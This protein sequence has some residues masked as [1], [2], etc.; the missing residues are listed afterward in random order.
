MRRGGIRVRRPAD[1]LPAGAVVQRQENARIGSAGNERRWIPR[2]VLHHK[3]LPVTTE[4][5]KCRWADV[6][7]VDKCAAG[8][9]VI[10]GRNGSPTHAKIGRSMKTELIGHCIDTGNGQPVA[11]IR[12]DIVHGNTVDVSGQL[13]L[14][15]GAV[16]R[17]SENQT[18][19]AVR[20]TTSSE[21]IEIGVIAYGRHFYPANADT[22]A[23]KSARWVLRSLAALPNA[24]VSGSTS[25]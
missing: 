3:G 8:H 5:G 16:S 15:P 11:V 14:R 6:G 10:E 17:S 18:R 13:Q 23:A 24:S 12:I 9:Q 25:S 20:I 2:V 1:Q 22:P 7:T 21:V 19:S 4:T